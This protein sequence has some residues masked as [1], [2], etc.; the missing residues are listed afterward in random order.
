MKRIIAA[1]A[2]CC[3]LAGVAHAADGTRV[4][5]PK[6]P[7]AADY[8]DDYCRLAR[9]FTDGTSDVSLALDRVEPGLLT[10]MIVAG[11][12]IKVYR[13]ATT[14]GYHYLPSG[15]SRQTQLLRSSMADGT[16]FLIVYPAMLAP[17]PKPPA[18]GTP[19]G[20]P[21]G[22]DR[23]AEQDFAHNVT[24]VALTE[25]TAD[26]IEIDT[27]DLKPAIAALQACTDDL[28][29][30][31]GIDVDKQKSATRVVFPDSDTSKWL[32]AGTIGFG[33]FGKLSGGTN[34]LRLMVDAAGKPTKCDVLYPTLD[35][36][37]NDKICKA[38]LAN[39]HF[40]P[41]LDSGGQPFASY[42][43]TSPLFLFGAPG[44]GFGRR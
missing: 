11:D 33:D 30:S 29:H 4:F 14:L 32:P 24:G 23:Q 17:T 37:V 13:S 25:G 5:K 10:R 34:Q 21:P 3:A 35:A 40:M 42:Y 7:W 28:A 1:A 20:P 6:G 44:G 8:G 15:D 27:G 43:V 39:A 19:P 36:G 22:Y 12:T 41:A 26:P 2:A 38:L 16:P 18:P 9:T 31:W